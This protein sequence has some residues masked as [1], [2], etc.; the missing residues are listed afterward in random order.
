[1]GDFMH[2]DGASGHKYGLVPPGL[3]WIVF[4]GRK[5]F[6]EE[7][8]FLRITWVAKLRRRR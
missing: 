5:V 4:K 3:G 1:M 2:I 7:L 8:V 6:N